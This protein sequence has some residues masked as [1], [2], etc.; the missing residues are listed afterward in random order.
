MS[1][2]Q[3]YI[4]IIIKR[5]TRVLRPSFAGRPWEGDVT[6]SP[7][8]ARVVIGQSPSFAR[9]MI[10]QFTSLTKFRTGQSQS[11]AKF[12]IGQSPSVTKFKTGQS[13][14]CPSMQSER[15]VVVTIFPLTGHLQPTHK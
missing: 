10:G 7:S 5:D 2:L 4:I 14:L 1:A 8:F 9:F 11:F 6:D 3:M 12:M 15:Q 13:E